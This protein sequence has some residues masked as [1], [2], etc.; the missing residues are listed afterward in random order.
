MKSL[1]ESRRG[2]FEKVVVEG[3]LQKVAAGRAFKGWAGQGGGRGAEHGE[4][5]GEA[6]ECP[7]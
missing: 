1:R 2:S 3:F 5:G 4:P 7:H 6:G